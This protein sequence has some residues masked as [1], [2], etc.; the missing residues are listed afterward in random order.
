MRLLTTDSFCYARDKTALNI[1]PKRYPIAPGGS[2]GFYPETDLD[3][4]IKT[5]PVLPHGAIEIRFITT[6]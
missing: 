5:N 6:N 3:Q 4:Q 2:R 1:T